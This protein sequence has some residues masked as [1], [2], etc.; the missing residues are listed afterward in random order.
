[1]SAP[2]ATGLRSLHGAL[3]ALLA[4]AVAWALQAAG[5]LRG[6][7][8]LT[9]GWRQSLAAKPG[10]ATGSIK[11]IAVDQA[12]LDWAAD[13][14]G[15][16]WPWPRQ[17][18]DYILEVCE[19]SGARAVAF[20]VLF[21]EPSAYG[22]YDDD[23]LAAGM[24]RNRRVA[25]PV[26]LGATGVTEP[27][28]PRDAVRPPVVVESGARDRI[29][30][31]PRATFPVPALASNAAVLASVRAD[32]DADG[33]FRAIP[34]LALFGEVPVP[35]L[36]LAAWAA[37]QATTG[38]V[39]VSQAPGGLRAGGQRIPLDA[40]GRAILR[41]R[42][43]TGTHDAISAAA[44][45]QTAAQLAEGAETTT[46]PREV[47]RDA[48]VFVGYT[49]PGLKDLRSVPVAGDYPGVEI[50]MTFLDNL[51]SGD[52]IRPIAV[53]PAAALV[54]AW[55]ILAVLTVIRIPRLGFK[56]AVMALFLAAVPL[57]GWFLF[58]DGFAWPVAFHGLSTALGLTGAVLAQYAV[59]GRQ[60]RFIK[61][62]FKHYLSGEVIEQMLADPSR[63]TLGGEKKE[64]TIFFSDLEGFSGISEKLG[65]TELTALLNTYLSAMTDILLEEGGTLDKYEGDAIIAFWNAPVNQE[66]HAARACRAALRCQQALADRAAEFEA[67]AGRPL[68]MR[69]G[70]HTGQVVV[71]NMGSSSRFNYTVL[72]DAANLASR[73]EGANKFTA[74]RLMVSEATWVRLGPDRAGRCLG[75]IR[76]IGRKTPV[77]IYELLAAEPPPPDWIGTW[78]A[79]IEHV[80]ARRWNEAAAALDAVPAHSLRDRY[81]ERLTRLRAGHE[82]DWDGV[83]VLDEK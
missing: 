56:L 28:W 77:R 74:T 12:S 50:H 34:P 75:S 45:L 9:W 78:N 54:A 58:V 21:T 46:L 17:V 71:G 67:A 82:P 24:A 76:V 2:G 7:E 23:S 14:I 61:Q 47:F 66:D 15:E 31:E 10:P 32:P 13:T 81:L 57:A 73:L 43:D 3:L 27:P 38:E 68:V 11:L 25:L 51:L 80:E 26:F 8:H 53:W 1:M 44:V 6:L 4:F 62:A 69:I 40:D 65:P 16:S 5:G 48:Y 63:L 42:G 22:L 19:W 33:V 29:V 60:K 37:A 36:G 72:G 55:T 79:A 35:S 59:E 70:I 64:L 49:A 18:Y 39:F 41:F 20:D 30:T 52:F 83:W